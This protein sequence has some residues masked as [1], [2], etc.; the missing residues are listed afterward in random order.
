MTLNYTVDQLMP[1]DGSRKDDRVLLRRYGRAPSEQEAIHHV[2]LNCGVRYSIFPALSLNGY[3]AV[4]IIEGSIDGVGLYDFVVNGAAR[5]LCVLY[6]RNANEHCT[7][8]RLD[9]R[10]QVPWTN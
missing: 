6:S 7:F 8:D 2:S 4:R 5:V 3:M 1:L 10:V 9:I